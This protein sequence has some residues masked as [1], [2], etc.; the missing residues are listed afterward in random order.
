VYSITGRPA[1]RTRLEASLDRGL[2]PLIGR[3]RELE[4]LRECLARAV[5][6][7]GQMVALV[8]DA[9]VGKSR[10][11]HELR[12]AV[13]PEK[14]T[15]LEGHCAPY[16]S[17]TP[18][19]PLLE[20]LKSSFQIDEGDHVLQIEEKLRDGL[21]QLDPALERIRPFLK[22]LLGFEPEA[23]AIEHLDPREKRQKTFE[24][25]RAL[26]VPGVQRRPLV[27]VIEDIH[28]IDKTSE[29][30][31]AFLVESLAGLPV[32]LVTTH[33]SGYAV[34]WA[35]KTYFTQLNLDV[36]TEPE[37][38]AMV[39]ALL[40]ARDVPAEVVRG[41]MGK[42]EGNPLF[43]EEIANAL[44]E[45]GVLAGAGEGGRSTGTSRI[46]LPGTVQDIIRARIDRLDEPVKRTVQTAAVIGREF[47]LKLLARISEAA[48]GVER[49]LGVLKHHEL[50]HETRFVPE[51]EFIFKHAVIQD[52]A[53]HTLLERRRRQLHGG[54]GRA[55]EEL[56]ADQLD[57]QAAILAYHYARSDDPAKAIAYSVRAGDRAA[58][59]YA[60]VEARKFFGEALQ[61]AK[62]L[63]AGAD[64]QRLQIDTS[65]KLA[66][67]ASRREHFEEDLSISR[68]PRRSPK[69][70]RLVS[71]VRRTVLARPHP[72]HAR[73]A[74]HGDRTSPTGPRVGR[75]TR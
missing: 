58:R 66:S 42:A 26:A 47:G 22:E 5:G 40:G 23:G 65:L 54:I 34:R 36:L 28:W 71:S 25:L 74:R 46:E 45:G 49:D 18:Y 50:I 4:V 60:T 38:T 2:T 19:F 44:T 1:A 21:H 61:M 53:Y 48:T 32:L 57:D 59:L 20:I 31:C 13:E 11:V 69:A 7:R 14:V 39:G 75:A 68:A 15:W 8:G 10:L 72:L 63:R 52:V 73:K 62:G 41:I 30:Y 70:G 16:A 33:R 9:G 29:D 64:A 43:V 51:L 35:D 27:L 37:T 56:Y 17:T 24:A 3:Q 12:R 67:V 55:I 6:R